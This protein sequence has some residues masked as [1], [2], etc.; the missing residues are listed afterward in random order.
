MPDPYHQDLWLTRRR[1]YQWTS[2]RDNADLNVAAGDVM[3]I[4]GRENVAQ[5]ILNRL[6]TRQGE[7][8]EL[9]HP[10]YGSRLYELVG[11]LNNTRTRA[12]A[13]RYIR[14]SLSQE[15]RIQEVA[16][17]EIAPPSRGFDRD[18][19]RITLTLKLVGDEE[20]LTLA[21]SLGG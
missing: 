5:A 12:L 20:L 11:E 15:P 18:Q 7:L 2:D 10:D 16:A 9:G 13:E 8:S 21:L 14:E 4:S 6:Y 19:L 3:A 17:V 1:I